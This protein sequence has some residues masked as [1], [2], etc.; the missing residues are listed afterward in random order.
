M[1]TLELARADL[2]RQETLTQQCYQQANLRSGD[3]GD[4]G[5][6]G[7]GQSGSRRHLSGSGQPGIPPQPPEG[8]VFTD[9]PADLDQT[10]SNVRSALANLRQSVAQ[11]G[12][13]L[14]SNDSTPKEVL[15]NF[16]KRDPKGDINRILADLVPKAPAV[17]QAEAKL[18]QAESDVAQAKLNLEYC[19]ITSD[20][21]GVVTRRNINNGNYVQV[22]QSLMA[23]QSLTEVWIDANFKETQLAE[24]HAW[25]SACSRG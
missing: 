17:K 5:R 18:L 23:V 21:T 20:I 12:L 25:V 8:K 6:P 16:R 3:G 15:E 22:G 10:Y 13:P 14:T 11:L 4:Q 2:E 7:P 1:A 9:V 19:D 24:M